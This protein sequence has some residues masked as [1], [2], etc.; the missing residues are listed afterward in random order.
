MTQDQVNHRILG[1]LSAGRVAAENVVNDAPVVLAGWHSAVAVVACFPAGPLKSFDLVPFW[2]VHKSEIRITVAA[3]EVMLE[4]S[5]VQA[6]AYPVLEMELL[7]RPA[8]AL[9]QDG[10]LHGGATGHKNIRTGGGVGSG[11]DLNP[12]RLAL[13]ASGNP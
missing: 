8:D 4:V 9:D 5:V 13:E 2:M 11:Q 7:V 1:F 6:S 10:A 3:D 12:A